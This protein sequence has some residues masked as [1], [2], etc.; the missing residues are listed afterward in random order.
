MLKR[1]VKQR[2]RFLSLARKSFKNQE[3][4]KPK[5]TGE[6]ILQKREVFGQNRKAESPQFILRTIL[7]ITFHKLL[8]YKSLNGLSPV[9]I[10]ELLNY[11]T[12]RRSLRSSD[13]NFLVI[14]ETATTVTYGNRS[15]AAIA[16]KLWNQA[17][18][19]IRQSNSVDMNVVPRST[20]N[21][22]GETEN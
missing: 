16:L 8:T 11:Y 2:K 6:N 3:N 21:T 5:R 12:P 20:K 9:Y 18:L 4:I 17:P 14:P 10:N 7:D 13:S 1:L 22:N 19:S 15:F